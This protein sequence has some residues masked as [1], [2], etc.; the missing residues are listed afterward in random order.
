MTIS[1][2]QLLIWCGVPK[3]RRTAAIQELLPNGVVDLDVFSTEDLLKTLEGNEDL[4][5]EPKPGPNALCTKR[6][7]QLALW[8]K[9]M[10]RL[11]RV[12]EFEDGTNA[13]IFER[14]LTAAEDRELNRRTQ[15]GSERLTDIKKDLPLK[16]KEEW[17]FWP[18]WIVR[19]LQETYGSRGI[20]LSYVL[21]EPGPPIDLKPRNWDV[22][23][24]LRSPH[25]GEE[26]EM[27]NTRVHEFILAN[28]VKDSE[29]YSHIEDTIPK[30][31]GT[32]AWFLLQDK[33]QGHWFYSENLDLAYKMWDDLFYIN[34]K[35]MKFESFKH[36]MNWAVRILKK[37]DELKKEADIVKWIWIHVQC[38]TMR[39]TIR[40]LRAIQDDQPK[41]HTV[42]LEIIGRDVHPIMSR[43]P[44]SR[45]PFLG[46]SFMNHVQRV[47]QNT[48]PGTYKCDDWELTVPD[49]NEGYKK[50]K[51]TFDALRKLACLPTY[52][53]E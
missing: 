17:M 21:R 7:L 50:R 26:Y 9:D 6:V 2:N 18:G 46:N 24:L 5:K 12:V 10:A 23:A 19:A 16:T 3:E 34:E 43:H 49:Y 29:A 51:M 13:I 41:T 48:R 53:D 35:D 30:K 45:Y 52:P 14:E 38:P 8:A 25:S 39:R 11:D 15:V 37:A 32:T 22:D 27:D 33:Y 31:D 42:I 1:T 28:I 20:P 47:E 44:P 40:E 36:H 4:G